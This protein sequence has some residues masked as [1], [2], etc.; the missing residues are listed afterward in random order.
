[1][2]STFNLIFGIW[3]K[4]LATFPKIGRLSFQSTGHSARCSMWDSNPGANVIKIL[5]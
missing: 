3:A 5:L 4:V 1:M 2:F